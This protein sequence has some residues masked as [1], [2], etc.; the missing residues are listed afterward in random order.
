M[1]DIVLRV[2]FLRRLAFGAS[3]LLDRAGRFF[4]GKK[5]YAR[6]QGLARFGLGGLATSAIHASLLVLVV[7]TLGLVYWKATAIA[8]VLPVLFFFNLHR[9]WIF[10]EVPPK[11]KRYLLAVFATKQV[12]TFVLATGLTQWL[13]EKYELWYLTTHLTVVFLIGLVSFTASVVIFR[14]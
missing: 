8:F 13:L 12:V 7:E 11:R 14:R 3:Y 1:L 6:L 5:L 10:G 2:R 9:Y 4:L